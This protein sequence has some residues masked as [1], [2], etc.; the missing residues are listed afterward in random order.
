MQKLQF[1]I[2]INAPREKVWKT[3]LEDA[4]YRQW[5]SAFCEGSSYE[6]SWEEGSEIRFLSP[7]GDGMIAR[8]AENRPHEFI[9]IA[10]RGLISKGVADTES[11]EAKS[12]AGARENYT[13]T[14]QNG[15]TTVTV[16]VDTS[17]EDAAMFE[18]MWPRALDQLKALSE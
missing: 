13:F 5:T 18:G 8:I 11:E 10:H 4:T 1:S 12:I 3:M 16:E 9:S 14:E 15:T 17:P 6:G 2:Q 7:G